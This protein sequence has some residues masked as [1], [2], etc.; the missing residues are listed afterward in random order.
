MTAYVLIMM[1]GLTLIPL[2]FLVKDYNFNLGLLIA[3]I[4]LGL[5][6]LSYYLTYRQYEKRRKLRLL[7]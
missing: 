1:F 3:V 5:I 7:K 6:P 2:G 4:G